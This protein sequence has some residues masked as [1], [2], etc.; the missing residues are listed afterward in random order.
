[1]IAIKDNDYRQLA[2][3]SSNFMLDGDGQWVLGRY[4]EAA[5]A[6]GQAGHMRRCMG[7]IT[8]AAENFALAAED[9]LSATACFVQATDRDQAEAS[10][11]LVQWLEEQKRIPA[12]RPDLLAALHQRAEEVQQLKRK[13]DDFTRMLM[14]GSFSHAGNDNRLNFLVQQVRELPGYAPLHYEIYKVALDLGRPSLA[15]KHLRWAA[16]FAPGQTEF[17]LR[18]ALLGEQFIGAGKLEEAQKFGSDFL[19]RDP[20]AA[21]VRI[22]LAKALTCSPN[23]QRSVREQALAV[24]RPLLE[25][26]ATDVKAQIVALGLSA[27]LHHELGQQEEWAHRLQEMDALENRIADPGI[28]AVIGD[29]RRLIPA[30]TQP[31][32]SSEAGPMEPLPES[33]KRVLF[34]KATELLGLAA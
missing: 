2:I 25:R 13:V 31:P 11:G 34:E 14:P 26:S 15:A 32:T 19:A 10:L 12:N 17:E 24:L 3:D 18:A 7:Q 30:P 16:A 22:M 23:G 28:K 21:P 27:V 4:E 1:M 29:F 8:C 5:Y 6:F 20:S 9:W 33:K